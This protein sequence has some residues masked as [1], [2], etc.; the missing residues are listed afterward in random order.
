METTRY[1]IVGRKRR[2]LL[3]RQPVELLAG[4]TDPSSVGSWLLEYRDETHDL[5]FQK[6]EI[7]EHRPHSAAIVR[8]DPHRFIDHHRAA[9]ELAERRS[10]AGLQA[11]LHSEPA[12]RRSVTE[13]QPLLYSEDGFEVEARRA[14]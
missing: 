6:I 13:L 8:H 14:A 3:H 1:T 10:A 2:G 12:E 5:G 4:E 11:L 7:H 9:A